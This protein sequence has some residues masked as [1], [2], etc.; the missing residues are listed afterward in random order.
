MLPKAKVILT[1]APIHRSCLLCKPATRLC[2]FNNR[3]TVAPLPTCTILFFSF[4]FPSQPTADVCFASVTPTAAGLTLQFLLDEP[5]L[6]LNVIHYQPAMLQSQTALGRGGHCTPD[7][8]FSSS[9]SAALGHSFSV[10][11]NHFRAL[12]TTAYLVIEKAVLVQSGAHFCV[13]PSWHCNLA[14]IS[15]NIHHLSW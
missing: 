10:T 2:A 8:Y 14:V 6:V 11:W 9:L 1:P 4:F 15:A 7:G 13:S 5:D 12:W 3:P